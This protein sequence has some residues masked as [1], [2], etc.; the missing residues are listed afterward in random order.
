MRRSAMQWEGFTGVGAGEKVEILG[1]HLE[2]KNGKLGT[3]E[4]SV[5]ARDCPDSAACDLPE[6]QVSVSV[7]PM[8]ERRLMKG[9]LRNATPRDVQQTRTN[10]GGR[11][12]V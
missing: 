10:E 9:K 7:P 11:R 1:Y 2:V 3:L 4:L 12:S 5:D 8:G 6:K